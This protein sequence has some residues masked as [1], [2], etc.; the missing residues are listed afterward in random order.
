MTKIMLLTASFGDGHKQVAGALEEQFRIRGAETLT[1]DCFR[2]SSPRVA[3]M[4]EWIYET[5]TRYAPALYGAS[6]RLT[7]NFGSE[8]WLWKTLALLSTKSAIQSIRDYQPD[9]V[10]QLFPDHALARLGKHGSR[11]LIG[12]VITDYSIHGRW[13]HPNVDMYFFPHPSVGDKSDRFSGGASRILS[14]IPVRASLLS[15][16]PEFAP[17][18]P[19]ILFAT[20]GR[21]VFA[22]LKTALR[23]VKRYFPSHHVYVMCGRNEQM[24]QA[25]LNLSRELDGVRPLPYV[26]N[27]GEW[28][29]HAEFAVIKAGG[30]TVTECLVCGCPTIAYRPQPGQEADNAA[31][32]AQAGAGFSAS[33]DEALSQALRKL[34]NRETR[35]T[36]VEA[37]RRN[38]VPDA[39]SRVAEYV[40][41]MVQRPLST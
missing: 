5:T 32:L 37:C 27:V 4:N 14:G 35:R 28:M 19:Y 39:A 33:D 17:E 1:M 38:A 36:M 22:S 8:N 2:R 24:K 30:L 7:Q 16:S 18:F 3:K 10:L 31:F 34:L 20:G 29:T 40:L 15:K 11:P 23:L 6:Y 21:G 13:F 26:A 9:A 25:V 12:V 41:D